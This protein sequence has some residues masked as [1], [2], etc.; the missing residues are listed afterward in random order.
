[1]K[2]RPVLVCHP[3]VVRS[4]LNSTECIP[5]SQFLAALPDKILHLLFLDSVPHTIIGR[6]CPTQNISPN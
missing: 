3:V 4:V 5:E 1:M 2:K 6:I